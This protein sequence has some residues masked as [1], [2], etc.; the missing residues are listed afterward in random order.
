[1][2]VVDAVSL[3]AA[4]G[5]LG[6]CAPALRE[7]APVADLGRTTARA[8]VETPP[9]AEVNSVLRE[10]DAA[11]ARR[12][13]LTA[14][15][16]AL[17]LYLAAARADE[18]RIEGLLG[19]AQASAWLI[20]HEPNGD[21][22]AA[23][24]AEAVQA[25]QWCQRR[26]PASIECK[27]RLALALGQQARERRSTG[28]DALPKIVALLQEVIA[29]APLMDN[30]GGHR[31]LALALLRAPGWPTGP[32]DPD[33]ALE[34]ARKADELAPDRPENLLALGEALAATGSP[35]PARI[36]YTRAE[37]LARKLAASGDPD[38]REWA[39]AAVRARRTLR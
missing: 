38:A 39:E 1:M 31:V 27:Y 22:R 6:A 36:A 7:P 30:A 10:A 12:P 18:G 3:G 26:A 25:C 33:A 2:R 14:V 9:A 29:E 35:E 28:L 4:L 19:A 34:H 23:L 5:L 24:A 15:S 20:E 11:F 16:K 37:E 13:D 17:D 32:G 8:P 21:R